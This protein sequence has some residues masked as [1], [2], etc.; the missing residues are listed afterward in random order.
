MVL[1]GEITNKN[2]CSSV[3]LSL[4]AAKNTRYLS[5]TDICT[6]IAKT[7]FVKYK[8]KIA[9]IYTNGIFSLITVRSCQFHP[10]CIFLLCCDMTWSVKDDLNCC[11]DPEMLFSGKCKS[12]CDLSRTFASTI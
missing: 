11:V 12:V 10:K 3:T 9:T 4:H 6:I 1:Y 8:C 7:T 5:R 2:C